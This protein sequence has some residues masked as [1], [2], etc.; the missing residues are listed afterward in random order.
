MLKGY[1]TMPAFSG[2]RAASIVAMSESMSMRSSPSLAKSRSRP[3][4]WDKCTLG[5][6]RKLVRRSR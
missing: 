5:H 3:R 2:E 4:R 6:S 1:R